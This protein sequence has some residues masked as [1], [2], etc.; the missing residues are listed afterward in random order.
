M[1]RQPQSRSERRCWSH[2]QERTSNAWPGRSIQSPVYHDELDAIGLCTS[3]ALQPS[4]DTYIQNDRT[5]WNVRV[6]PVLN[7]WH[8]YCRHRSGDDL[9]LKSVHVL[10][11]CCLEIEEMAWDSSL[12]ECLLESSASDWRTL[13]LRGCCPYGSEA[14]DIGRRLQMAIRHL[15]QWDDFVCAS[16]RSESIELPSNDELALLVDQW[17]QRGECVVFIRNAQCTPEAAEQILDYIHRQGLAIR[18]AEVVTG[19]SND[20]AVTPESASCPCPE[21]FAQVQQLWA[22]AQARSLHASVPTTL[23][24]GVAGSGGATVDSPNQLGTLREL[25]LQLGGPECSVEVYLP[26]SVPAET[27]A[28]ARSEMSHM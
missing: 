18:S 12:S 15:D 6:D 23:I 8:A 21:C 13:H 20:F 5:V 4:L 26:K 17:Q 9:L 22:A 28:T 10:E 3:P 7:R 1:A 19:G 14:A 2:R 24:L 27:A 16:N 25:C 11:D